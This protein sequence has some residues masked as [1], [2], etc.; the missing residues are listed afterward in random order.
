ML[1][2]APCLGR[3]RGRCKN[4]RLS[5]CF[6]CCF[7]LYFVFRS[8]FV[9]NRLAHLCLAML[10]AWTHTHDD[11]WRMTVN[12]YENRKPVANWKKTSR[13]SQSSPGGCR[14]LCRDLRSS[15]AT[16]KHRRNGVRDDYE[17]DDDALQI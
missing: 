16:S 6:T 1:G 15:G 2:I 10:H 13:P 9:K 3:I 11:A 12:T 7:A 5:A 14:C 4:P 17:D 8:G